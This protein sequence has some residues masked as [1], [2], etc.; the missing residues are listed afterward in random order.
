VSS[1]IGVFRDNCGVA[2][3][4]IFIANRF[5][6]RGLDYRKEKFSTQKRTKT[7]PFEIFSILA[8]KYNWPQLLQELLWGPY[9]PVWGFIPGG[10]AS[11]YAEKRSRCKMWLWCSAPFK[12]AY[13]PESGCFGTTAGW[14]PLISSL[15]IAFRIGG[16]IPAKK[17][18]P[19]K[20]EQRLT[21]LNFFRF[22]SK[23]SVVLL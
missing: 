3:L 4:N 21:P 1:G 10:K 2:S 9:V 16:S 20:K 12:V 14:H 23:N 18:F 5:S 7:N 8:I 17:N 13:L 6:Y 22:W 15:P 11:K 19:P